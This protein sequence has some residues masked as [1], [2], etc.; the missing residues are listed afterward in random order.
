MNYTVNIQNN[1]IWNGLSQKNSQLILK[2]IEG[3][4]PREKI[5]QYLPICLSNLL[6]IN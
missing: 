4:S 3:V 2:R 5:V 6:L 1:E